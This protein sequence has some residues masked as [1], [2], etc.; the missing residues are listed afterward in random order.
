MCP[1]TFSKVVGLQIGI[2][3]QQLQYE[4]F[5]F[6]SFVCPCLVVLKSF[7][8]FN[9]AAHLTGILHDVITPAMYVCGS[10]I[11]KKYFFYFYFHQFSNN[12]FKLVALEKKYIWNI[13]VGTPI[14]MATK[15]KQRKMEDENREFKIEWIEKFA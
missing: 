15:N 14:N 1:H 12:N 9:L 6:N 8:F 5:C 11:C 10:G 2:T 13:F 7:V 3:D 4:Q